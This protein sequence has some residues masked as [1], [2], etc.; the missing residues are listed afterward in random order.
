[1]KD[2]HKKYI[3]RTF[4]LAKKGLG[5]V[6]PNPMVGCVIVKKG[7]IIGEGYHKKYGNEHAEINAINSVEDKKEIEGSSIYIN[8]EPCS[9]HGKTPPCS[10]EII[11][12]RPK[13]VIISNTDPNPIV[14]GRG[15]NRL[16]ENG[17]SVIEKLEK[18]KGYNLNKRFFKNQ[19]SGLPYII[20]K[21][22]QTKDGYLAKEDGSSKWISN[23]ISRM[24]VHKW[25]SEEPGILIGVN[26]ANKDNPKL[27]VRSWEG[28]NPMR[29]IIDPNMRLN[30]QINIITDAG[31]VLIYN[32]EK[33]EQ[34]R[35]K[36][37]I[38][39]KSFNLKDILKDI[40]KKGI[41]S[42]IVEGGAITLNHFIKENLWD[43][44]RVFVSNK[45]FEKGIKAP[46]LDLNKYQ[47]I[48]NNKLFYVFNYA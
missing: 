26:T 15:I 43:E 29:I 31:S 4:Y 10:D 33:N 25:R 38:Q 23:D 7:K 39:N 17:I 40:L 9:H 21:W 35:N 1:M 12:Y 22:A 6:S 47:E 44:A 37:F 20:L 27:N 24:M 14:N 41:G 5:N 13:E 8:L 28:N 34:I 16:K 2:N 18:E 19:E 45:K 46:K 36:H 11:K 48:R 32:K 3:E 42:V 30:N